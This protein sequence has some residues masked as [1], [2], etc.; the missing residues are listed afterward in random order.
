M[1][2]LDNSATTKPNAACVQAM[3]RLLCDTWGNPS[4]VHELGIAAERELKNARKEVAASLG[5]EPDRVFFTSGGTE[6]DNWAIFSTCERL[7]KRGNHIVTT[8]VEHHAVL[9]PM[10]ALEAKGFEVTYLQ[11]DEAGF[12]SA[13]T[14]KAALRPDTILVSIMMVNNE[15]G[16]VMALFS[17]LEECIPSGETAERQLEEGELTQV[18]NGWLASLSQSDRVLFLRRYWNGEPLKELEQAYGLTHSALAKR[19]YR[20]RGSLRKTLEREGYT[21]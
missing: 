11:P 20:L 1:I 2:Y 15:S 16:A 4:S 17:E 6:A 18:L 19:M 7:K 5:A 8:A 9:H 12:V 21:L 14:L 3:T 13:D 10:K